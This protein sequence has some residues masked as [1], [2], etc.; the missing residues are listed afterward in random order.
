[1]RPKNVEWNFSKTGICL[2]TDWQGWDIKEIPG[3]VFLLSNAGQPGNHIIV[4][5]TLIP[6][7]HKLHRKFKKTGSLWTARWTEENQ[8]VCKEYLLVKSNSLFVVFFEVISHSSAAWVKKTGQRIK[9]GI[10][11]ASLE[12]KPKKNSIKVSALKFLRGKTNEFLVE[13][14]I[15]GDP[16]MLMIGGIQIIFCDEDGGYAD[17]VIFADTVL[18]KNS[19]IVRPDLIREP[20]IN[21]VKQGE[22]YYF[23]FNGCTEI[24]PREMKVRITA[25]SF[26][27]WE[28]IY[29]ERKIIPQKI[30]HSLN[31][32]VNEEVILLNCSDS[33][34]LHLDS[35]LKKGKKYIFP[36]QFAVDLVHRRDLLEDF[37]KNRNEEFHG[38]GMSVCSIE[39][40]TVVDMHDGIDDNEPGKVDFQRSKGNYVVIKHADSVYSFYAHLKTNSIKV[41]QNQQVEPFQPIAEVGNSGFSTMP[42]LHFQLS[43]GKAPLDDESLPFVF[44]TNCVRKK[45]PN[46]KSGPRQSHA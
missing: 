38:Y 42:H 16:N 41:A 4:K 44:K 45:I 7:E 36:Q 46:K 18:R 14:W 30:E 27:Q 25:F 3:E 6:K 23:C 5:E 21:V 17:Q 11:V 35:V 19:A 26:S 12:K 32:P 28:E 22:K 1:M 15:D 20:F 10:T 31:V 43:K 37:N 39:K 13:V 9:N 33:Q 34:S 40:G 24:E 2:T 29:Y 8:G